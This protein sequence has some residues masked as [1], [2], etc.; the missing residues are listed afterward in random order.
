MEICTNLEDSQDQGPGQKMFSVTS[1]K[2]QPGQRVP[3]IPF[4]P[5]II[6]NEIEP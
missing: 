3:R 4:L 1:D 5:I 6:R 2:P